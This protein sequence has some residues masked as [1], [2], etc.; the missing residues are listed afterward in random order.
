MK[1]WGWQ[2]ANT[3]TADTRPGCNQLDFQTLTPD[4]QMFAPFLHTQNEKLLQ[5]QTESTV[6]SEQ[7]YLSV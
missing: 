6:F 1:S 2:T 5:T 3:L 7:P 4:I